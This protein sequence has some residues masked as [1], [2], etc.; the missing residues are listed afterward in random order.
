VVSIRGDYVRLVH[1]GSIFDVT[2]AVADASA[3]LVVLV[4]T[5]DRGRIGLVIDELLGQQQVVIKSLGDSHPPIRGVSGGAILGDGRVALIVDVGG[6]L[7]S[8]TGSSTSS[9]STSST[10]STNA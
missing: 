4:D 6:L 3:G 2:D 8:A 7:E 10:A 1:L 9:T 5:E